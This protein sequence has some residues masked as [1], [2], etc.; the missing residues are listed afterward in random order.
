MAARKVTEPLG[1]FANLGDDFDLASLREAAGGG[2]F[3][4]REDFREWCK[5]WRGTAPQNTRS[6]V[7]VFGNVPRFRIEATLLYP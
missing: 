5:R 3:L 4:G 7:I 1:A 2:D 6:L